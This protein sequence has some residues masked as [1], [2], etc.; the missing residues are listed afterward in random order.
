MIDA[1]ERMKALGKR[2][3]NVGTPSAVFGSAASLSQSID[4][5]DRYR[6]G[7]YPIISEEDPEVA[8]GL[9]SCLCY[10]LEQYQDT[11]VYRCFAK[12]HESDSGAEIESSDYQFAIDEW[13]LEGL[14]DNIQVYGTLEQGGGEY[15]LVL[16]MEISLLEEEDTEEF[17]FGFPTLSALVSDLPEVATTIVNR[18]IEPG[19]VQSIISY[20]P[21]NLDPI[22]L[23]ALLINVF[24]WNLDVYLRLW[25]VDWTETDIRQQF[26]DLAEQ[27]KTVGVGFSAWCLG[28]IAKQVMQTGLEDCG[29]VVVPLIA[30]SFSGEREPSPGVAAAARGLADLGYG[31][32]AV[33][34]LQPYLLADSAASIWLS[35]I[36][37]H[38]ALGHMSEAIDTCQRA[39]EI[40]QEHPALYWEYSQLLINAEA[41]EWPVEELLFIDP[42]EYD[43]DLQIPAEIASAL[44]QHLSR[45]TGDL[46][47]LQL[48]LA[49][50]IDVNDDDIW[51]YLDRL[52]REDL[53]GDF[54]GDI[55]ERILDL[56]DRANAYRILERAM[57]ANAY[58]HVFLAQ[59]ALADEDTDLAENTITACRRR[60]RE[61]DDELEI[62]LQRLELGARLPNFEETFAELKL[63]LGGNHDVSEGQVELLEE[64][65]EIAPKMIDLYVVLSRCYGA[66]DDSE[67]AM[68]VLEDAERQAGSHPQ[69][70]LGRARILWARN[71][72]DDAISKL[73]SGLAAFP[74]DVN[75]LVQ[76][77]DFLITNNQL[78]DARQYILR[79]ESIAPSHRSIWRTRRLVAQKM[80]EVT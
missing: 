33:D 28:M 26:S 67:S 51:L 41:V 53:Q 30:P 8:M 48:A 77:A 25:G 17:S 73:N 71:Q 60:F 39:L 52:V 38:L 2:A 76:M 10:L 66:W 29:E 56:D 70:N 68:E 42:D 54:A 49:Y 11:R 31:G 35:M 4:H 3:Q 65:V 37:I 19:A 6:I 47:A 27:S 79:A 21:V 14:A 34:L 64:A 58:A 75:L 44:K 1:A 23:K 63:L 72:R 69:I 40:G 18:L 16:F 13:E 62:E 7:F 50:M 5:D 36:N 32:Q 22:Q 78:E 80:T 20:T 45:A 24:E 57:D 15:K 55:I 46:G 59:L 43:E 12:I 61:I 9:A 74:H